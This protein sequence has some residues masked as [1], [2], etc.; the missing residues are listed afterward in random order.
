M[1]S[2][3]NENGHFGIPKV[4]LS[5]SGMNGIFIDREGS[6]GI[7]N[8]CYGIPIDEKDD[9]KHMEQQLEDN[10]F[11]NILKSCSWSSYRIDWNL[12]KSFKKNFWNYI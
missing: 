10:D 7:T 11:V 3:T 9:I 6:R 5:E 8:G 2:N 4:I 12:F 1:Y